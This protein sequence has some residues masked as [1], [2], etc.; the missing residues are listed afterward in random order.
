MFYDIS[1]KD[2]N[3]ILADNQ[4]INFVILTAYISV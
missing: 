3:R 4:M 2:A 1:V